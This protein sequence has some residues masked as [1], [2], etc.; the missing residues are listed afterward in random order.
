VREVLYRTST[1]GAYR[2]DLAACS[3]PMNSSGHSIPQIKVPE[4][5]THFLHI[6]CRELK[7]AVVRHSKPRYQLSRPWVSC[8][9]E[10]SRLHLL[11]PLARPHAHPLTT[12]PEGE[13]GVIVRELG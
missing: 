12:P 10:M 1:V 3:L 6:L 7:K 13:T 2:Y 8:C 4:P 9:Q 11:E 5:G